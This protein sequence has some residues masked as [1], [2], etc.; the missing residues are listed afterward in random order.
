MDEFDH[1]TDWKRVFQHIWTHIKWLN[2]FGHIN[3]V[4]MLKIMKKFKKNFFSFAQRDVDVDYQIQV[5][6]LQE[7]L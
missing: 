5:R 1:M 7:Y 4:A 2:S 3:E 6:Y